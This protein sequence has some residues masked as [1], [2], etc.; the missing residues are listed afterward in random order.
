MG[1]RSR[2]GIVNQ[3][4]SITSIY[5]HWDG[6]YWHVGPTLVEHYQDPVKIRALLAEGDASS[7]G[8]EIGFKHPF[9]LY[10]SVWRTDYNRPDWRFDRVETADAKRLA[11]FKLAQK[12][13]ATTF[14]RRDRGETDVDA[15]VTPAAPDT[16]EQYQ[17]MIREWGGQYGYLF[18]D[19]EWFVTEAIYTPDPNDPVF[20]HGTWHMTPFERVAE[21]VAL[22]RQENQVAA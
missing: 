7:L 4:A 16:L 10:E 18:M 14:Y 12:I 13:G 6:G 17:A 1:T 8:A 22:Y 11:T 15:V 3:D 2:I 19:G 21:K 9:G 20:G 5:V